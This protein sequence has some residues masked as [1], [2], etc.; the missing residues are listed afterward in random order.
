MSSKTERFVRKNYLIRKG[1]QIKF[2]LMIFITT[3]VIGLIALWTTYITTWDEITT[4]VQSRQFY[5]KIRSAYNAKNEREN[6]AL[7]NSLIVVEFSEI[8]ERVSAILVLR[9]LIG[10]F[11]LFILSIFASHK[12]AGPLHRIES[13]LMSVERGNLNIDLSKLRAG[14]EMTELAQTINRAIKKLREAMNKCRKQANRIVDL[15]SQLSTQKNNKEQAEKTLDELQL[16]AG[17]LVTEIDGFK[18][19]KEK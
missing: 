17:Q 8:F 9:I 19:T 13:A 2:S 14:D 15:S 7:I 11:L 3:F 6:V 5:E 4:Q 10:S 16:I 12:I 1:F 18:T